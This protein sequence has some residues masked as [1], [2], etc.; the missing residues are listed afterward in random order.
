MTTF[1]DYANGLAQVADY[2]ASVPTIDLVGRP[3]HPATDPASGIWG[4]V[5]DNIAAVVEAGGTWGNRP[6]RFPTA[7][8][9][10]AW[11]ADTLLPNVLTFTP[12]T[13]ALWD[14]WRDVRNGKGVIEDIASNIIKMVVNQDFS[15]GL[16]PGPLLD[17]FPYLSPP[18]PAS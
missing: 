6:H 11:A 17:Y 3:A 2:N 4:Q 8:A 16:R 1:F 12:G 9:Y 5:R 13:V 7:L 14:P 10:G 18:P 15:S